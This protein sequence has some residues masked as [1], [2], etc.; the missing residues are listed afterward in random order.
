LHEIS[1]WRVL[2]RSVD[3]F[4]L[5]LKLYAKNGSFTLKTTCISAHILSIQQKLYLTKAAEKSKIHI[6]CP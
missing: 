3:I 6:S 4:K 2:L 1:Y 5:W